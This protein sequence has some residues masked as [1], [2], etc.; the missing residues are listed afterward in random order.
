VHHGERRGKGPGIWGKIRGGNA[1][2]VLGPAG[3]GG[4]LHRPADQG[5]DR[6]R[7]EGLGST[8]EPVGAM[9]KG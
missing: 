4:N 3:A 9:K 2:K 6:R 5:F 8:H 7:R 1:G